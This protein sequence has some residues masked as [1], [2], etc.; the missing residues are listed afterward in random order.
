MKLAYREHLEGYYPA[1]FQDN[2]S[3]TVDGVEPDRIFFADDEAGYVDIML[4]KDGKPYFIDGVMAE[5]RIYGKVVMT[6][7]K[8]DE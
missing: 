1:I 7:G 6:K 4:H 2:W 3:I 5:Q 8:L